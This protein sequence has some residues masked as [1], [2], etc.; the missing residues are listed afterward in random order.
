MRIR[1]TTLVLLAALA[2]CF[3]CSVF[4]HGSDPLAGWNADT[5]GDS[6]PAI[7]QDYQ[8]YIAALPLK[9]RN[10]VGGFSFFRDETGKHAVR[11]E[12]GVRSTSWA[13]VLIYDKENRRIKVI[14]YLKGHFL[15]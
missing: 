5:G 2:L 9:E 14:K 1:I 15:S 12:T 3:G 10:S 7:K 4:T 6:D 8:N 13:H 11:F